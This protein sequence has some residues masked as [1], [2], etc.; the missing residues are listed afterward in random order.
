MSANVVLKPKRETP[1]LG[2]HPWIFSGAIATIA[3]HPQNGDMVRITDAENRFVG[4]GLYNRLSQIRVRVYSLNEAE[5]PDDAFFVRRVHEAVSWRRELLG[6]GDGRWIFSEAD[7]LS[8]LTV[9]RYGDNLAVQFTSLALAQHQ[10]A[11]LDA[12]DAEFSP[13][14]ILLR[15]EQG[16]LE[17]EGLE[18]SDSVLR[19][20]PDESLIITEHELSYRVNLA[21]GQKTG[22]YFDQRDNRFR[23]RALAAG[24][25]CLDVC[26]YT[27]G[28]ALNLARGGARS[29]HA[30]D[31]SAGALT[32]AQENAQQN[33]CDHVDFEKADAFE[34][35]PRYLRE[36]LKF[37]LIVLDPPKFTRSKGSESQALR[38]YTVLNEQA[39]RLLNPNGVLVTCSCSGRVT[40]EMFRDLLQAAARRAGRMVRILEERGAAPDH[41]VYPGC[42]ETEYLKCFIL[43]AQ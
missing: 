13:K 15:T 3:G 38:G 41:P 16:I 18:L 42:P 8:G 5:T 24:K 11:L 22:Y 14:G 25:D 1:I 43:T 34:A 12:L 4:W 19:G 10:E 17:E 2:G 20:T 23:V 31:V 7:G 35:L 39:L 9:D 6:L 26:C 28:F 27:G 36:D 40:R 37:G 32:L 33:G 21:T 29:V 30:L